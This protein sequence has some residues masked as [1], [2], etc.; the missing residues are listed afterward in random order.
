MTFQQNFERERGNFE[1]RGFEKDFHCLENYGKLKTGQIFHFL[2]KGD[3][4]ILR[5]G[6]AGRGPQIIWNF[7]KEF[8]RFCEI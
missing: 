2:R 3:L 6:K 7:S 5:N 1:S 4:H 8:V